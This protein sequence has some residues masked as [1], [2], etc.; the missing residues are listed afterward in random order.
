MRNIKILKFW[1]IIFVFFYNHNNNS[2]FSQGA[3]INTT[4]TSAHPSAILDV[5]SSNKGV[6]IPRVTETQKLLIQNPT[7]G[8]VIYQ[9]DASKGFW[10][11]NGNSWEQSTANLGTTGA[12][13]ATGA[14]GLTG[15]TGVTG[16]TGSTG[17]DGFLYDGDAIGVTP[18]WDGSKWVVNSYNIFNNGNSVGF[19]TNSPDNSALV[20]INSNN[21]GFLI[22]RMTTNERD[23]IQNPSSGLQIYNTTSKC[24]EYFEYGIWQEWHCAVCPLPGQ[25]GSI[26]GSAVVCKG[27]NNIQY[28]L[29]AIN[30]A[31]NYV[32]NYS[33]VGATINGNNS[34][35][36]INFS[37]NATSGSLNVYGENFCG[38]GIISSN[39]DITVNTIP[40]AP[41]AGSHLIFPTEI[42]WKWNSTSSALGYKY[43]TLNDYSSAVDNGTILSFTQTGLNCNTPYILYVWA[44][45][46]CGKSNQTILTQSTAS[47]FTCGASN[48]NFQYNGTGSPSVSYGTVVSQNNTCWLDRNLGASAVATSYD[49]LAAYGDYFQWGR[50][51][52]GHQISSSTTLSAQSS[53]PD[54]GHDNFLVGNTLW[55]IGSNPELL[56]LGVNAVNNP[57]PAGWRIP[58]EAEYANELQ[59]WSSK[60]YLGAI[61]SPLKLPASGYRNY[62]SGD[63]SNQGSTGRYYNSTFESNNAHRLGFDASTAAMGST[64]APAYAFS[65][66]CIMDY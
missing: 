59:S 10:F 7:E 1:I 56:W 44:Y 60:T 49:H 34:T 6:L 54:P 16:A 64:T 43:N 3:A 21:R 2:C 19:G 46:D 40:D 25:A 57:C 65:I 47:C 32:W 37:N 63:L 55:Y 27:D 22:P 48:V 4:N 38:N 18:Y 53:T 24:F 39:F 30:N 52:D 17:N 35:I 66:R 9:T 36:T 14:T 61:N 50:G 62:N 15:A 58:T 33:G 28:T 41:T 8:L 5:S 12:I 26:S 29:P 13:G 11:F 31:T 51:D 42:T 45:N 20:D 23:L